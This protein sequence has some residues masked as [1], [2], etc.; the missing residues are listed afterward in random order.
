MPAVKG[1]AGSEGVQRTSACKDCRTA[2]V[3]LCCI[4]DSPPF[5]RYRRFKVYIQ[6]YNSEWKVVTYRGLGTVPR[7]GSS[8]FSGSKSLLHIAPLPLSDISV[9]SYVEYLGRLS[10]TTVMT[11]CFSSTTGTRLIRDL[12]LQGVGEDNLGQIV[13][14]AYRIA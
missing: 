1:E 7:R 11:K 2:I 8:S 13:V 3:V 14:V 5:I 9:S 6:A 12:L 10:L 4:S